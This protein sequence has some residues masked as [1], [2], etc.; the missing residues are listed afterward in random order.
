MVD[1]IRIERKR[2]ARLKEAAYIVKPTDLGLVAM[3]SDSVY[4]SGW[5]ASAEVD[6]QECLWR[7]KFITQSAGAASDP[8]AYTSIG[9]ASDKPNFLTYQ[10][11]D[12]YARE[13][14]E[15]KYDG[16]LLAWVDPVRFAVPL[17]VGH[18]LWV[19]VYSLPLGA[20]NDDKNRTEIDHR[21]FYI[22]NPINEADRNTSFSNYYHS[23]GVLE[24][25][26]SMTM[27][28]SLI[29]SYVKAY[30]DDDTKF[31]THCTLCKKSNGDPEMDAI[32]T[33]LIP[34]TGT[35]HKCKKVA[36]ELDSAVPSW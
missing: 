3:N 19:C 34:L 23:I 30:L 36:S 14:Y 15:K 33:W 12:K 21:D 32:S 35:C 5:S 22:V 6:P 7:A 24:F 13:F 28:R 1:D 17:S 4:L 31:H 9:I 29:V 26:F 8:N 16:L 20:Y 18:D 27:I 25:P 2:E 11:N 10:I